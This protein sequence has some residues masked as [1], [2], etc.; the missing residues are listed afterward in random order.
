MSR[1]WSDIKVRKWRTRTAIVD[2]PSA[3]A[4]LQVRHHLSIIPLF[5]GVGSV[6]QQ[7]SSA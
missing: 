5:Y 6:F 4:E 7:M 2:W 3:T 1:I